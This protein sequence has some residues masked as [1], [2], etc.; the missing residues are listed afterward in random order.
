MRWLFLYIFV[1]GIMS[2]NAEPLFE[3]VNSD[4]LNIRIQKS[5]P[6]RD[7]WLGQDKVHHFMASAFLTGFSY[8]AFRQEFD[9]NKNFSNQAAIT[10]A[11][12]F[13]V[14]K[15][16]YDKFSGRGTPSTKD[17]IADVAGIVCGILIIKATTEL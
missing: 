4:S 11:L 6:Q 7:A 10:T 3:P 1:F 9:Q 15:E 17:L 2:V 14:G 5:L 16:M 8:Y 12:T 13:G